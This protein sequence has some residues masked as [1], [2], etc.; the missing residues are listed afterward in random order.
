VV[1]LNIDIPQV[2]AAQQH[3]YFTV[4]DG[5]FH[6]S[7]RIPD[8]CPAKYPFPVVHHGE[9]AL[10]V[11]RSTL[12]SDFVLVGRA[13]QTHNIDGLVR[14]HLFRAP[15][16]GSVAGKF[17]KTADLERCPHSRLSVPR[18]RLERLRLRYPQIEKKHLSCSDSEILGH[19]QFLEEHPEYVPCELGVPNPGLPGDTFNTL[20]GKTTTEPSKLNF[21][22]VYFNPLKGPPIYIRPFSLREV[23][24]HKEA[25][26]I[27]LSR[28]SDTI[29]LIVALNQDPGLYDLLIFELIR[30]DAK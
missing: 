3:C 9:P 29:P 27:L 17:V 4:I 23:F 16:L 18:S 30:K 11:D 19:F 8:N 20:C 21:P 1:S 10:A 25:A 14:Y 6:I 12:E 7:V 2:F 13:S 22:W 15:W 26:S 24:E 5:A 28:I